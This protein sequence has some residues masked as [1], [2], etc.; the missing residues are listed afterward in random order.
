MKYR[1]GD[2]VVFKGYE[3]RLKG[4]SINHI[5]EKHLTI[6]G[7]WSY[8]LGEIKLKRD[9]K[10]YTYTPFKKVADYLPGELLRGFDME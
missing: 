5:K 3:G 10:G 4:C 2:F 7:D 9:G 6:H 1:V 8:K